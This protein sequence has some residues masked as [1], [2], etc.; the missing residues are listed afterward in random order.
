MTARLLRNA[1]NMEMYREFIREQQFYP[2]V[3]CRYKKK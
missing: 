2:T 3:K 1:T